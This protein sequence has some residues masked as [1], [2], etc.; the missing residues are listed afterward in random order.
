MWNAISLVQDWT[1][2][3]V[4]IS[5][6]DNHYTTGTSIWLS[7]KRLACKS[8]Y[9]THIVLSK[10]GTTGVV[11]AKQADNVLGEFNGVNTIKAIFVD[12]KNANIGCISGL[13]HFYKIKK[14]SWTEIFTILVAPCN[15]L[16][17]HVE[18]FLDMLMVS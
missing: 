11:L 10:T 4:S 1:R 7:Q 6:D 8:E 5:Y 18:L 3:A 13:L 14:K 17:Y 15:K 9:L 12:N 16:N 2:V